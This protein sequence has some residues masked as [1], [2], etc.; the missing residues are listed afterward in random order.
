[1]K[2]WHVDVQANMEE[3]RPQYISN[4]PAFL[5]KLWKMVDDP[6]TESLISWNDEGNSFVIHNPNDFSSSLLPFYYKHSNMASFVRQLNMYGFHKVVAVDSGGLKSE[7]VEDM[8]FAHQFFLRGHEHLLENIK[9]KAAKKEAPGVAVGLAAGATLVPSSQGDKVN[10]ILTEV[11]VTVQGLKDKQEDMDGK[12]ETMKK[13]NEALWREVVSLRQKH[14]SQQKIVNKLIQFLVSIVQPRI[15]PSGSGA[16]AGI[17]RR[18]Q[19]Q[20]AIEDGGREAKEPK[21]DLLQ[22]AI[23]GGF[24]DLAAGLSGIGGSGVGVGGSGNTT[25]TLDTDANASGATTATFTLGPDNTI[26]SGPVIRDVTHDLNEDIASFPSNIEQPKTPAAPTQAS[27]SSSSVVAVDPKLIQHGDGSSSGGGAPQVVKTS[28]N[29]RPVLTREL[30]R[31]DLDEDVNKV[32]N[33]LEHLKSILSGQITVDSS[34]ITNL[35]SP[36]EPLSTVFS[37]NTPPGGLDF[38]ALGRLDSGGAKLPIG[39]ESPSH[40]LTLPITQGENPAADILTSPSRGHDV[41][42]DLFDIEADDDLAASDV[43]AVAA[44]TSANAGSGLETRNSRQPDTAGLL[45]T[46]ND[47]LNTPVVFASESPFFKSI[48]KNIKK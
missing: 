11:K 9:R 17:K 24:N 16:T 42:P 30:S 14:L 36:E 1:M 22:A 7:R 38:G 28:A 35:F 23:M 46:P 43:M 31:E 27:T 21:T 45:N 19:P 44:T 37:G 40:H 18:Y 12:M 2:T 41:A 13:E 48:R 32:H 10:D 6:Q 39:M 33:D 3:I 34:L 8:E 25:V 47:I 29:K 5:T 26:E 20:F 15:Q 4:V